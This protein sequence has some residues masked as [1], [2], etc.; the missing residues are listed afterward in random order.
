MLKRFAMMAGVIALI[1]LGS[2]A[3]AVEPSPSIKQA[4]G[5]LHKG[6]TAALPSL[7]KAL[8]QDSP[9][10]KGISTTATLVSDL[11]A[12]IT[13]QKPPK[14]DQANYTKLAKAY[15][16]SAAALKTAAEKEDLAGAKA[17]MGKLQSSCMDCHKA[18][19]GK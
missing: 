7:K 16:S 12:A 11:S 18:H 19:K 17:A 13:E 10:W 3:G 5:K 9:D 4:M 1:G 6:G 14:G 2:F 8:A 15:A